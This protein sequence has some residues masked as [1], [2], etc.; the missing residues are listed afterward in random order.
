ML[1]SSRLSAKSGNATREHSLDSVRG[2]AAFIVVLHHC[3]LIAL[4]HYP[5]LNVL[6][7]W[8]NPLRIVAI[9]RPAVIVFFAL[10]GTALSLSLQ[11]N[12]HAS[13]TGFLI[14]RF[15]RIYLPFAAAILLSIVLWWI[16]QPNGIQ[17]QSEWFNET[18][19]GGVTPEVLLG[20]LLMLGR[21]QDVALNDAAWSLVYEIRIS[22]IF[23]L[24]FL[25]VTRLHWLACMLSAGVF[26]VLVEFA[27][28]RIGVVRAPYYGNDAVEASVITAHFLFIFF[29]GAMLAVY[30]D[31]IRHWMTQASFALVVVGWIASW[32]Y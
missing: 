17:S 9:G 15:C 3:Y 16:I 8:W 22:L 32:R 28:L 7:H 23:P 20:H 21:E 27:R 5:N 12:Q 2:I 25:V 31:Q 1:Q 30:R 14:K 11:R 4:T 18:W 24:L 29:F 6:Y 19:R 26:V 10:S 13:Y